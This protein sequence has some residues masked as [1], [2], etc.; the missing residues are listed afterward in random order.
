MAQPADRGVE[1]SVHPTEAPGGLQVESK[2]MVARYY[3]T[4]IN[5]ETISVLISF[6]RPGVSCLIITICLVIMSTGYLLQSYIHVYLIIG[7]NRSI[8]LGVFLF[9][10]FKHTGV[11]EFRSTKC[12]VTI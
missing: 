1:V 6:L 11:Q 4:I 12:L 7:I 9:Q 2:Y 5:M 8:V 3:K 10:G